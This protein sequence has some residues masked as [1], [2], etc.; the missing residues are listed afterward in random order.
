MSIVY[1]TGVGRI[2][3]GCRRPIADCVCKSA[4]G[5]SLRVHAGAV[6]VARQTQGRAGKA[7][8][9]VTGLPLDQPEL[10]A[11][12]TQ[13]KRRCGSGGTVRQGVIEIQGEHR[14]TVVAELI[15][16]GYAAKR[17]GG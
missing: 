12:A 5:Q 3:P 7:V 9:V 6:R 4:T 1:R 11:L 2:C 15:R 8:T 17:S 16:R 14:D 13:L 10:E